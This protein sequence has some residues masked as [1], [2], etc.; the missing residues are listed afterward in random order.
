MVIGDWHIDMASGSAV[1]F[2]EVKRYQITDPEATEALRIHQLMG[3][4]EC[5]DNQFKIDVDG[6]RFRGQLVS[7]QTYA[8]RRIREV[9]VLDSIGLP[10]FVVRQAMSA[11]ESTGGLIL[12]CGAPGAGKS[13]TAIAIAAAKLISYGGYCLTIE[14]P[15]EFELAGFHG[16]AGWCEQ[17]EAIGPQDY[18]NKVTTALRCFPSQT[19]GMLYLGEVRE[20][21][22][23]REAVKI[24]LS[25][26]R[27]ISTLH[28]HGHIAAIQR[29][30]GMM[31]GEDSP[32]SRAML[33]DA[34]KLILFQKWNEAHTQLH[35]EMLPVSDMVRGAIKNGKLDSIKDELYRL[36][37]ET[38]RT[39]K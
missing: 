5:K 21:V 4:V 3:L 12:V 22:T 2:P 23:A 24:G 7:G 29:V 25:G 38:T 13:T 33:A 37:I 20:E 27:V 17:I 31:G 10:S 14:D 6:A 26:F 34:L 16:K 32:Q 1:A 11:G 35:C 9:P 39:S 18:A 8:F 15:I 36:K 28:S 30:L 19:K